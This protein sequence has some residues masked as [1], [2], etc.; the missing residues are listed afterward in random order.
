MLRLEESDEDWE[1][2]IIENKHSFI[3]VCD[4]NP[5]DIVGVLNSREYFCLKDHS[6]E[7]VMAQAV[8]PAQFVP[9]SVR[10]DKLFTRMKKNRNHFSVVLDEH[11]G[12][13]GIVTM[14]DLLEE[15]VGDLEDDTSIPPEQ[16]LIKKISPEVWII[17]GAVS[18]DKAARELNVA[19]PVERYD[20]FAGFVF[21]LLGQVPEDGSTM[22]LEEH[23]LKIKILEVR[24]HRLEKAL[25]TVTESE[26]GKEQD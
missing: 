18:L 12:M 24:D 11:G 9:T 26:A 4:K 3:P 23:G 20:T 16:P 2:T 19:L 25:V 6:R 7:T 15:L 8:A 10:T 1:K 13:M 5:D 14:K 22:E 17:N 21:S